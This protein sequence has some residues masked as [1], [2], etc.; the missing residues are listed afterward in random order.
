MGRREDSLG[1]G[2][3]ETMELTVEEGSIYKGVGSS[4]EIISVHCEV[5]L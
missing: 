1:V 5:L 4:S 2:N 3:T